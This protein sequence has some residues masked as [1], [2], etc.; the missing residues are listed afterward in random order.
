MAADAIVSEELAKKFATEKETPYT[1]WVAREGLDIIG[2]FYVRK[3]SHRRAEALGAAR[4]TRRLHQPRRLA[5]VQRLL[6]LRD[7]RQAESWRRSAS[8]SRK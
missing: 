6:R 5:H 2:A 3:P 1:R 8:C 4:R 7:S